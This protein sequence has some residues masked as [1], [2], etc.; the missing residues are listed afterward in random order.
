MA[1]RSNILLTLELTL[2]PQIV[3]HIIM[4]KHLLIRLPSI[5]NTKAFLSVVTHHHNSE[6]QAG[7]FTNLLIHY[8]TLFDSLLPP[9]PTTS[10]AIVTQGYRILYSQADT[11]YI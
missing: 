4:A 9:V 2:L 10:I 1:G 7:A 3:P 5:K 8:Q 11:L 6:Y